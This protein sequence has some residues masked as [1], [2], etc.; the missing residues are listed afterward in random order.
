VALIQQPGASEMLTRIASLPAGDTFFFYPVM[1]TMPFLAARSHVSEYD[2]FTPGYTLPSQYHDACVSVMRRAAWIVIDRSWM[3]PSMWLRAFPAMR[4]AEP[5]EAR[6]F[7][8]DLDRG[9]EFTAR[10]GTFELR[11]RRPEIDDGDCANILE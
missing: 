7:E 6:S 10:Y 5:P 2:I 11:H 8:N 4:N 9:F 3:D 1:P